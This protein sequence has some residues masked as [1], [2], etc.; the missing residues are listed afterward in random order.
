MT[1]AAKA[2]STRRPRTSRTPWPPRLLGAIAIFGLAACT[3][4]PTIA[5]GQVHESEHH[6]YRVA[7]VAEGLE[8]P[9]SVAFLPNGDLLVTE[10]PGRLRVI[11]NGTLDPQPVS[12]V[13][14]VVAQRQGGLLDVVLHPRFEQNRLVYLSYSKPGPNGAT[15]A[16][17]RGRFEGDRL[18]DVVE[19]FEANAWAE[20]GAHFGSR[21]LFDREGYLYVTIGDRGTMDR[22]QERG[23]H[24]GTTLRLHDDGRVPRDNPFVGQTGVLPEIYTYGN[25]NAQGMAL[26]PQTG[27]VWQTEHGPR[28][29]DEVNLIR[30]GSNYGWPLVTHGIGYDRT[31]ITELTEAPGIEPPLLH[32]TPSIAPSGTA[33]YTG[34]AFP[35]WRGNLFIGALAGQHLARVSFDGTRFVEQEQLLSNA[36]HRIRDVRD[37]PDGHI[38]VLVDSPNAPLLRLEPAR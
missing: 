38:Y 27:E 31:R 34:D 25:R 2:S 8:H 3:Q 9:W 10:R 23:D 21:L 7:T 24:A 11:R 30:A 1:Q 22:A 35:A 37:G 13:P 36:G 5:H 15:T 18:S 4:Q 19:V 29:G 17:V 32:W 16:V 6:S 28:G 26:H 14:E 12:G 33:F 20:T